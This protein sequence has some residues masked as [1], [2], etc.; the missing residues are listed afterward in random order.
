MKEEVK[1][2]IKKEEDKRW[3]LDTVKRFLQL[4][5]KSTHKGYDLIIKNLVDWYK[6]A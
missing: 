6:K 5:Q 3:Y 4:K 2:Q 1:K